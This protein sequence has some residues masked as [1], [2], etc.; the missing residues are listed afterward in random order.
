MPPATPGG[1]VQVMDEPFTA[2]VHG[3]GPP[4]HAADPGTKVVPA[5]AA[6]VT[7]TGSDVAAVPLFATVIV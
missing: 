7:T 6:S 5:G 1:M 3:G 2:T 4:A